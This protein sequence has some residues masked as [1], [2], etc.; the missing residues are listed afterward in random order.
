MAFEKFWKDKQEYDSNK[1][2]NTVRVTPNPAMSSVLNRSVL[3]KNVE[4]F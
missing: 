3:F 2:A 4:I 1:L